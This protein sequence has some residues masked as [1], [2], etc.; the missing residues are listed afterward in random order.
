MNIAPDNL[1]DPCNHKRGDWIKE[2]GFWLCADCFLR[3]DD[4]PTRYRA[5]SPFTIRNE[6]GKTWTQPLQQIAWQAETAVADG[7]TF[8]DFLR[9]MARRFMHKTRPSMDRDDAYD[10]AISVLATLGD[11][12]GDPAFCWSH[13]AAR[14]LADDEMSYWDDGGKGENQ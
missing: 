6:D 13:D 14:E 2:K 5:T 4:R 3:L 1:P 9:T 11:A 8:N 10:M 12:Y 7:V